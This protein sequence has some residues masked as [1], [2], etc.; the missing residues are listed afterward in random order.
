MNFRVRF[1]ISRSDDRSRLLPHPRE[2]AARGLNATMSPAS[3]VSPARAIDHHLVEP[4][5]VTWQ[6]ERP[7]SCLLALG[8]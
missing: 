3:S 7:A 8:G 2:L 6:V 1:A 5:S 4:T